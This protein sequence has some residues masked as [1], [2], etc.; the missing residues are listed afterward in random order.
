MMHST[1]ETIDYSYYFFC[2]VA[3]YNSISS[4]KK[5]K[6]IFGWV[7]DLYHKQD[8]LSAMAYYDG[9]IRRKYGLVDERGE[10]IFR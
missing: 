3:D 6:M 2:G 4:G 5:S 10:E 1:T 9:Y 8:E 7:Y